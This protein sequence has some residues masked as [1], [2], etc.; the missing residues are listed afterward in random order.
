MK[1]PSSQDTRSV[2]GS[3]ELVRATFLCPIVVDTAQR[4]AR[5][6]AHQTTR[7]PGQ[8]FSNEVI[9]MLPQTTPLEIQRTDKGAI[10][11]TWLRVKTQ[12]RAGGKQVGFGS[13]ETKAG[14]TALTAPAWLRVKSQIKA[15]GKQLGFGPGD[16]KT[17]SIA[18]T[19]S[20]PTWLRIKSQIRAGAD[21]LIERSHSETQNSPAPVVP[22]PTW[23]RVKTQM[24]AGTKESDRG[25]GETKASRDKLTAPSW[26]K[27]K[28]HIRSGSKEAGFGPGEAK[29]VGL[30][31]PP[32]APTWLVVKSQIKAGEEN[33]KSGAG[34]GE[35]VAISGTLLQ[36]TTRVR[37]STS[38]A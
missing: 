38:G 11:P 10:G 26:L 22:S 29:D 20:A 32:K 2:S 36:L 5:L 28:S 17:R 35:T 37:S 30:V 7:A 25:P 4:F 18:S 34:P 15:G 1:G 13:G 24:R 3:H 12:I 31:T 8:D 27:I 19:V 21:K 14:A 23:L 6:A 33:P 9:G 16:A